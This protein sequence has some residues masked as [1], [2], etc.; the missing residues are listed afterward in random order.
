MRRLQFESAGMICSALQRCAD[1]VLQGPGLFEPV[2]LLR[3]LHRGGG[4]R[5][6]LLQHRQARLRVCGECRA[7]LDLGRDGTP[8]K[9]E[10]LAE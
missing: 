4:L 9:R 5:D 7:R 10:P 6:L 2:Q 1:L 3:R 8:P